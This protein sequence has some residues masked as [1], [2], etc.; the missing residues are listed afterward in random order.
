MCGCQWTKYTDRPWGQDSN[1]EDIFY[2]EETG[3]TFPMAM[4]DLVEEQNAQGEQY[5]VK[6]MSEWVPV[7]LTNWKVQCVQIGLIFD[8]WNANKK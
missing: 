1:L 4:Q 8:I 5:L 7:W 3:L 2:S 6:K